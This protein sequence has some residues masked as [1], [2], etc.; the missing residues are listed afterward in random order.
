MKIRD[1]TNNNVGHFNAAMAGTVLSL[2]CI[3]S[4]CSRN[5]LVRLVLLFFS[6]HR[7]RNRGS[8]KQKVPSRRMH[9]ALARELEFEF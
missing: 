9:R 7:C 4:S 5:I 8:Q 3:S 2:T 6:F 1:G